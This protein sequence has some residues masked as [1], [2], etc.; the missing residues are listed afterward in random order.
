MKT[1][2]RPV[3]S[4]VLSILI[5]LLAPVLRGAKAEDWNLEA[6]LRKVEEANGGINAIE[7]TTNLRVRGSVEAD[8]IVYDFLLLK[9]RPDKV[10]IHLMHKGRA[11]ETGFNGTT[12]W[13]RIWYQGRDQVTVLTE[14][15][16]ANAN[17]DVDFDGPLIGDPLPGTRRSF[18]GVERIDRVDYFVILVE[19]EL[20]RTRHYIDSRTF[21]EWKTIREI[22]ENG[23]V[24][25]EVTTH[26][27][28]YKRHNTIWLAERVE[29]RLPGGALEVISVKDAEVD[30]GLLDRVFQ[31][32][33]EWSSGE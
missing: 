7:S 10:R 28:Q 25:G 6:V 4:A 11:I 30:P 18:A 3:W 33:R 23:E 19:N 12:G 27:Y 15:E 29:R 22:L 32:P 24:T 26:Y 2:F 17:L 9:K 8:G 5:I 13:R 20:H 21:R 1:R 31:V 16:L 14:T